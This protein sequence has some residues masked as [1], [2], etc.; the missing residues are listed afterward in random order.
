MF[1]PCLATDGF[2]D[3]RPVPPNHM[4]NV[5]P[6]Q[7]IDESKSFRAPAAWT[8][9]PELAFPLRAEQIDTSLVPPACTSCSWAGPCSRHY[10]VN[11]KFR[12]GPW[13]RTTWTS[14]SLAALSWMPPRCTCYSIILLD[15]ARSTVCQHPPGELSLNNH[16]CN[17]PLHF[18]GL[19]RAIRCYER[20]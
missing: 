16:S 17:S 9:L 3:G 1:E 4:W 10:L 19:S 2:K 6:W 15:V 7:S 12:Y 5:T 11:G 8:G 13:A 18:R 14:S 20:P